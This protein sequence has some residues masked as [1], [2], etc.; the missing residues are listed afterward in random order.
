MVES[1]PASEMLKPAFSQSVIDNAMSLDLLNFAS[2]RPSG[3]HPHRTPVGV[4]YLSVL[5]LLDPSTTSSGGKMVTERIAEH[6]KNIVI[7]GNE[8]LLVGVHRVWGEHH[9]AAI[10]ALARHNESIWNSLDSTTKSKL[11]LL[12]KSG[13]FIGNM[14]HNADN[15]CYLDTTLTRKGNYNPNQRNGMVAWM[16]YAYIFY[17]GASQVNAVLAD[18]DFDTWKAEVNSNGFT[19]LF[20][21]ISAGEKNGLKNLMNKGGTISTC[22]VY[23]PG[24]KNAFTFKGRIVTGDPAAPFWYQQGDEIAYTPYGLF[25][26][27]TYDYNFAAKVVD[28]ASKMSTKCSEYGRILLG[29]KTPHLGTIGMPLEWNI[30]VR[31]SSDYVAWGVKIDYFHYFT[32][33]ATGYWDSADTEKNAVMQRLAVGM[34]VYKYRTD[35]DYWYD[36]AFCKWDNGAQAY[37]GR[38]YL[39]D[40]WDAM[41]ESKIKWSYDPVTEQANNQLI[42]VPKNFRIRAVSEN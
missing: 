32:L 10:I 14:Q 20:S 9:L 36:T 2:P 16:S 15:Q 23:A 34:D 27:T 13:V 3:Y 31:S 6:L 35:G 21:T 5:S 28:Q 17:G 11:T 39:M 25:K 38:D 26:R 22:S 33:L 18:F 29:K 12:M 4:H 42:A 7:S 30:G 41:T 1:A 37:M 19:N 24:V 40:M 8:P